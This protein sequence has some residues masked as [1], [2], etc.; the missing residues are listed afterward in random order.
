[1]MR[2]GEKGNGLIKMVNTGY[3]KHIR[4]KEKVQIEIYLK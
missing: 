3:T 1:M 4:E 2:H